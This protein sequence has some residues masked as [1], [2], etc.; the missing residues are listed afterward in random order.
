MGLPA[1]ELA[2]MLVQ[3]LYWRTHHN[4][5]FLR[6]PSS[7]CTVASLVRP[8]RNR[9]QQHND[10]WA[11]GFAGGPLS[12]GETHA[13]RLRFLR[14]LQDVSTHLYAQQ[15]GSVHSGLHR[16]RK[17]GTSRGGGLRAV[18]GVW[19]APSRVFSRLDYDSTLRPQT[20][21]RLV[22]RTDAPAA[23]SLA[24]P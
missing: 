16:Q 7:S 8:P 6:P 3:Q 14:Q 22:R 20:R 4:L 13:D 23:H 17:A 21:R 12:Y 2:R 18:A 24:A 10:G 1:H 15:W 11:E 5:W 19:T 9:V